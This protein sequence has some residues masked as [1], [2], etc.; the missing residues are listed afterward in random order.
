MNDCVIAGITIKDSQNLV[1]YDDQFLNSVGPNIETSAINWYA[2][3][4]AVIVN[5][6]Y[7]YTIQADFQ[8][9]SSYLYGGNTS[10]YVNICLGGANDS[11]C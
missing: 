11:S 6:T 10:G 1:V 4:S 5:G 8:T 2:P 9:Y 7:T 3:A